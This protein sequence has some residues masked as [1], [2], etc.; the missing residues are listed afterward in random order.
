MRPTITM[1]LM[2]LLLNACAS[3]PNLQKVESK[4]PCVGAIGKE[5][6][7][8]FKKEFQKIGEPALS[9]PISVSVKSIP[10]DKNSFGLY[11]NYR[12][13]LGKKPTVTYLDSVNAK[14]RFYQLKI[15]DFISLKTQLIS[16]N[17]KGLV[18]YL[19]NDKSQRILT[20]VKF[21][22][23]SREAQLI[24]E[25]DHLFITEKQGM[26]TIETHNQYGNSNIKMA[27]LQVFNFETSGFCWKNNVYGKPEIA[28]ITSN[29]D[30]CPNSTE[31]NPQKINDTKAYLKF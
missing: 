5:K 1:L 7:S 30:S 22:A 3:I 11:E 4:I 17:N 25:A 8:L 14:P 18:A 21:V 10:F 2:A 12:K 13:Q 9:S 19:T 26:L 29:G 15:T 20:E 31:R 28:L 27:E 23:N 6:S 16:E 24:N